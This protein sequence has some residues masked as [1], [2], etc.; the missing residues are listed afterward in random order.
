MNV[1]TVSAFLIGTGL[2]MIATALLDPLGRR[3]SPWVHPN[4]Q[5]SDDVLVQRVRLRMRRAT[6]D[7]SSIRVTSRAG[8]VTLAG[9]LPGEDVDKLLKLVSEMRGVKEVENQLD[10]P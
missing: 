3:R 4:T 7:P 8:K 5:I 1:R 9:V 6:P 10:T 2:G